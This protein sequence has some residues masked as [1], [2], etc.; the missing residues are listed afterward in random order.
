MAKTIGLRDKEHQTPFEAAMP[1]VRPRTARPRIQITMFPRR[2]LKS[3]Y[4]MAHLT[5]Y[6]KGSDL[7]RAI[8]LHQDIGTRI[9]R[10]GEPN[11]GA[12]GRY[13]I[14]LLPIQI[15]HLFSFGRE[16]DGAFPDRNFK[17]CPATLKIPIYHGSEALIFGRIRPVGRDHAT[18]SARRWG[19]QASCKFLI[20]ASNI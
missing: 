4:V 3:L 8:G 19:L 18:R 9:T 16:V 1:L 20:K 17:L 5:I 11:V 13:A 12:R 6:V 10:L 7:F 15:F 14:S 2:G